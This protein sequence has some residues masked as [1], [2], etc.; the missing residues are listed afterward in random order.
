MLI[1]KNFRDIRDFRNQVGCD[2][3]AILQRRVIEA[4][5][6]RCEGI[7]MGPIESLGFDRPGWIQRP[8]TVGGSQETPQAGLPN[9]LDPVT[10]T[11]STISS[12]SISSSVSQMLKSAGVQ[13]SQMLEMMI[14][15]MIIMSLLEQ[16]RSGGSGDAL[17]QLAKA[18]QGLAGLAGDSS[19]FVFTQ[20][21]SISITQTNVTQIGCAGGSSGAEGQPQI[22]TTA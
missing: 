18:G 3:H 20:S 15:L 2:M 14:A 6:L 9:S 7:G 22:D 8:W 10:Q 17:D 1:L 16:Q 4:L 12:Q 11:N 5:F 13:N 21:S 19:T